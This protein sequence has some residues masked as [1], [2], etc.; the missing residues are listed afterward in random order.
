MAFQPSTQKF[1]LVLGLTRASVFPNHQ[2]EDGDK[3][4][5]NRD[6]EPFFHGLLYFAPHVAQFQINGTSIENTRR[7]TDPATLFTVGTT[8]QVLSV[9][10]SVE[11]LSLPITQKIAV[12][13]P[14]ADHRAEV[15]GHEDMHRIM[16]SKV[17]TQSSKFK[18]QGPVRP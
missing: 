17:K 7:T 15:D 9:S 13:H 10:Y 8:V 4:N 6:A 18:R 16:N 12:V 2:T 3:Y 14:R 11:P 5:Y 1:A